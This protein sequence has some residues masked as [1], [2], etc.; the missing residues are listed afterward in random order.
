MT[1]EQETFG[2]WVCLRRQ[3]A[4]LSLRD[5][6]TR[7]GVDDTY[8]SRVEAGKVSPPTPDVV[9]CLATALGD[10]VDAVEALGDDV[11]AVEALADQ[12]RRLPIREIRAV[13][14]AY[15]ELAALI[16]RLAH[17]GREEP[18]SDRR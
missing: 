12:E 4:E 1:M 10:D 14:Q 5:L 9:R 3:A 17:D 15:P 7:A 13:L 8:L 6:G 18:T 2:A 16:E 11:D